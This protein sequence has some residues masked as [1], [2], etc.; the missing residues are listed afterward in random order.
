VMDRELKVKRIKYLVFHRASSQMEE[1]LREAVERIDLGS[2]TPEEIDA[3]LRVVSLYDRELERYVYGKE[4]P[5][6][7]VRQGLRILG[8]GG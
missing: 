7:D 5:P 8:I 6:E 1:L 2:L 3:V 4:E